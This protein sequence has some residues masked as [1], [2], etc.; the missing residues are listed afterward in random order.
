MPS[1]GYNE[2][3]GYDIIIGIEVH[4]QLAT[5]SKM[6]CR[7]EV[8]VDAPPNTK[9]CPI[10]LGLPGVLPQTNDAAIKLGIRSALALGCTVN[11]ESR[12]ARKH[13]FSPDLPKGYQIT[14]YEY[15]LAEHG[16]LQ[17]PGFDK[18]VRIRRV[19]LEEDAGKLTHSARETLVDFNRCGVPLAEIVTDPDISSAA[20]AD[21]YLKELRLILR[22]LGV[23]DAEMER[24]HFRCEPNISVRPKGQKELGVR[25]EIK[26]LNSFKAVREGI[27]RAVRDQITW[28]EEGKEI[29]QTTYLWDEK[30]RELKPMRA[31]ET[32]ADYRYFPEPDLPPLILEQSEIDET[33]E[34]IREEVKKRLIS[35]KQGTTVSAE[36]SFMDPVRTIRRDW[37]EQGVKPQDVEI[38]VAEPGWENYFMLLLVEGVSV[39][40]ASTWLLNE[41][42]GLLGERNE[43]LA[44]FKVPVVEMVSLIT[45]L[46]EGKLTRPAA[47]ELLAAM[48]E[49]G[50]G[51][52]VLLKEMDLGAVSDEGL[53]E[54]VARKVIEANPGPVEKYRNGKTGVIGFLV[55]QCMKELRGKADPNICRQVLEKLLAEK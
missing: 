31:K 51:A 48:A 39:T 38:L 34:A 28:L 54:D 35:V 50:K 52:E 24:G 2:V 13:Y 14:Q 45:L 36:I 6:F 55:G 15:P 8:N 17:L 22:T 12:W 26:N 11:L 47:K 10:C 29:V 3:K 53:L 44:D 7:C 49:Q 43:T 1:K 4:V 30:S 16:S 21:A 32:A 20:E 27:D 42:R 19:H 37:E 18:K 23:S 41:T 33:K 46:R 25:S 9:V 5:A 40:E